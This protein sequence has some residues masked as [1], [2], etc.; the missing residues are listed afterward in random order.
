[1]RRSW[2]SFT[3]SAPGES[4]CASRSGELAPDDALARDLYEAGAR[5]S[6]LPD[7]R[8]H[9]YAL[10]AK[11]MRE[12]DVSA[13]DRAIAIGERLDDV[14]HLSFGLSAHS[15]IAQGVGRLRRCLRSGRDGGSRSRSGSTIP[16][17][18]HCIDWG[19]STAELALGHLDIATS[20]A[21]RH[22]AIAARL[23]PHHEVHALGQLLTLD[24]AAGRWDR[25]CTSVRSGP[26]GP[27]PGTR[28]RLA[29][30]ARGPTCLRSGV[31]GARTGR[32]GPRGSRQK[33]RRWASRATRSC[34]TRCG[35]RLALICGRSRPRRGAARRIG[36]VDACRSRD[37]RLRSRTRLESARCGRPSRGGVEDA[38]RQPFPA[39]TS[40]RSRCGRSASP[41]ATR[42]SS[43]RRRSAS[44]RWASTGMP[45]RRVSWA[46]MSWAIT[47][48]ASAL[49]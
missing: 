44:R 5:A 35:A 24:E 20:H 10:T 45:R 11:A 21:L 23:T 26:S 38:E 14:E 30:T 28:A 48:E 37:L 12:D 43:H 47:L 39:R 40:S 18:S 27:S 8:S 49:D 41:G 46:L 13:A 42:R 33:S 34:S 6:L 7:S 15:A 1:M 19:S 31:R 2:P 3:A 32:R 25:A 4:T 36:E 29:F 22:E 16:T 9:G 17:T